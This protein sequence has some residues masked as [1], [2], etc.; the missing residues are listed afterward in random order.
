MERPQGMQGGP[1][2]MPAGHPQG[3]HH[4]PFEAP[5]PLRVSQDGPQRSPFAMP[6]EG[7]TNQAPMA[8]PAPGRMTPEAV[9]PAVVEAVTSETSQLV[10]RAIFGV[11][12]ELDRSE[13]LERARTLPGIRNVQ[14]IGQAETEA[15]SV[16]RG[17]VQRMGFGDQRSIVLMSNGGAIDFIQEPGMSLA[18]LREG[19]YAA[20]VRETL[21]IVA[22]ELAQLR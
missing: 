9:S 17:S 2:A 19:H 1:V 21:I 5:I 18:V 6:S 16:L 4:D 20:G 13:I 11:T 14:V 8:I 22:R 7:Q 12:K 3:Q 10:L 15:M